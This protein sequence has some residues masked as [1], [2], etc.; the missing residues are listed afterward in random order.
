VVARIRGQTDELVDDHGDLMLV[1]PST[2]RDGLLDTGRGVLFHLES[3]PC[4]Y[5]EHDSSGV[6]QLQR[7]T[8]ARA[9]ERRL[10]CGAGRQEPF[11]E[12]LELALESR[13]SPW[14]CLPGI[15]PDHP[16][17]DEARSGRTAAQQAPT[18]GP[19]AGVDT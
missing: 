17:L 9:L 12:R 2:P 11:D 18:G 3:A 8:S 4:Q 5:G 7:G 15:E 14:K 13:Q 16:A 1:G 6:S 19:R 10:D